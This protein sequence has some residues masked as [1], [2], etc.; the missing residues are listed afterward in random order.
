MSLT[1]PTE[2]EKGGPGVEVGDPGAERAF[3]VVDDEVQNA[4]EASVIFRVEI[5]REDAGQQDAV[6]HFEL[7]EF[8][9]AEQFTDDCGAVEPGLAESLGVFSRRH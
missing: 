8:H 9:V 6:V 2:S 1:A 4:G 7:P 5:E 3:R